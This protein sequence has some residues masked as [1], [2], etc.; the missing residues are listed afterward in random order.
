M[1]VHLYIIDFQMT[2]SILTRNRRCIDGVT[3]TETIT[4]GINNRNQI[5]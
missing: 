3:D 5:V 1:E 4:F 2:L